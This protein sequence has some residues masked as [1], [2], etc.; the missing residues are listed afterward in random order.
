[1]GF[2]QI[3]KAQDSDSCIVGVRVPQAQLA[4]IPRFKRGIFGIKKQYM[5]LLVLFGLFVDES[6]N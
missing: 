4:F 6:S 3:G 5:W 1:M 2:R